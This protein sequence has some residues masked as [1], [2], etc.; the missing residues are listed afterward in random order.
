MIARPGAIF[1]PSRRG[2]L[3]ISDFISV[4]MKQKKKAFNEVSANSLSPSLVLALAN[5]RKAAQVFATIHVAASNYCKIF[6]RRLECLRR[7]IQLSRR[8]CGENK[9][10]LCN[11]NKEAMLR[12]NRMYRI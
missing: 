2:L 5:A 11:N 10:Q 3:A 7:A 4:K 8:R 1:A 6:Y 12:A 9:S